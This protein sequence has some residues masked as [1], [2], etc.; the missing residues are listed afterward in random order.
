MAY[1]VF[2]DQKY[3]GPL[4]YISSQK[5]MPAAQT[6]AQA[7]CSSTGSELICRDHYENTGSSKHVSFQGLNFLIRHPN[8]RMPFH[9]SG[10]PTLKHI[11]KHCPE[12]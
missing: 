4:F 5:H 6:P 11:Q 12:R 7:T 9:F 10:S 3:A 2:T 8:C 1:R